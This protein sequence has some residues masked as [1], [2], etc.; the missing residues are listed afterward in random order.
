[1]RR[2]CASNEGVLITPPDH[3]HHRI[4]LRAT[5]KAK[6]R[7]AGAG[8][9]LC[10][11]FSSIAAPDRPGHLAFIGLTGDAPGF[12]AIMSVA[13]MLAFANAEGH[14]ALADGDAGPHPL[15]TIVIVIG[16][17]PDID[18][19]G[20]NRPCKRAGGKGRHGTVQNHL[21]HVVSP[22]LKGQRSKREVVPTPAA[23]LASWN[24]SG[25]YCSRLNRHL[26]EQS[27]NANQLFNFACASSKVATVTIRRGQTCIRK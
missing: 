3:F 4:A 14:A 17:L 16:T 23:N 15:V 19:V 11:E 9:R 6:T 25:I 10:R 5:R 22:C 8:F 13:A 7:L 18:A 1:M 12:A 20:E 26:P 2:K 24:G 21:S 27:Q